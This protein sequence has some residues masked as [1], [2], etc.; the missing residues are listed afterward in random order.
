MGMTNDEVLDPDVTDDEIDPTPPEEPTEPTDPEEPE[1]PIYTS[2]LY[3]GE[4]QACSWCGALVPITQQAV[5]TARELASQEAIAFA[6]ASR[7]STA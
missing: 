5:H 4:P 6:Q 7:S 2:W 1:G 3:E